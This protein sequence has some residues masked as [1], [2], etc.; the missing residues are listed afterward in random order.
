M[1]PLYISMKEANQEATQSTFR[2][3]VVQTMFR[4]TNKHVVGNY[5]IMNKASTIEY[6]LP[7]RPLSKCTK[8][9]SAHL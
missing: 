6:F 2:S 4:D 8:Q 9:L 7:R 5:A 1:S 3:R